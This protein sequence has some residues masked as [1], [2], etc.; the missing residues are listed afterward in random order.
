M[1][2]VS[3]EGTT[4]IADF[5][6]AE[7]RSS[8]VDGYTINF[9]SIRESHDLAPILASLPAATVHVPIGGTCFRADSSSGTATTNKSPK[10][11]T[12]STCRPVTRRKPRPE[13]NS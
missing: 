10:P 1:P 4:K 9:V 8:D 3:K 11:A 13:P 6:V 12:R 5:G 7:D 2:K